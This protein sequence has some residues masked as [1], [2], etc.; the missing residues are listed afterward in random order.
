MPES[1]LLL[2]LSGQAIVEAYPPFLSF[3]QGF[4]PWNDRQLAFQSAGGLAFQGR[5]QLEL[6]LVVQQFAVL[7]LAGHRAAAGE[8]GCS[9]KRQES[10]KQL[11][12]N[13]C[14]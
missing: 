8:H 11:I 5:V 3:G 9:Q 13:A 10:A 7:Q 4:R 12:H 1:L 14:R 6:G 2:G